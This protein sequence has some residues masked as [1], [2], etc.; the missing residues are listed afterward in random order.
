MVACLQRTALVLSAMR[1]FAAKLVRRHVRVRYIA[2]DDPENTGAF[3][4]EIARAVAALGPPGL[5]SDRSSSIHT[6]RTTVTWST[7]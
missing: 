5:A 3:E 6:A 1:H 7:D 2:L 4:T